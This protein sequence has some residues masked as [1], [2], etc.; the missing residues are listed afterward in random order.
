VLPAQESD[1]RDVPHVSQRPVWEPKPFAETGNDIDL[2]G[3]DSLWPTSNELPVG[4]V[5]LGDMPR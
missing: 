3:N 2:I 5:P 1:G 4:L